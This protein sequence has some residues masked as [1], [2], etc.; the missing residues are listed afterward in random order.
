MAEKVVTQRYRFGRL[1]IIGNFYDV[2]GERAI[3]LLPVRSWTQE[4]LLIR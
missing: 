3:R 4:T 2:D 1:W